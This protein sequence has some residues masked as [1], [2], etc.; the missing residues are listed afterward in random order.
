M[1]K[2]GRQFAVFDMDG[3]LINSEPIWRRVTRDTVVKQYGI[4]PGDEF[5]VINSGSTTLSLSYELKRLYPDA[6]VEPQELCNAIIEEMMPQICS[7]PLLP[8][9]AEIL[10]YFSHQSIS[11]AIASSSAMKL[12]E[13]VVRHHDFPIKAVASGYEV[14]SSK[15]H[16]AVF[17]L[18]AARLSARPVE[19]MAW[20][21]SVN[22]VIAA[23]S[24][25]MEVF[26]VPEESNLDMNMFS[27]AHHVH[28]TLQHSLGYLRSERG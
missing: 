5:I 4:D 19:C 12:I 17:E 20:E 21:D 11:I 8:G 23:Y 2:P 10:D 26:A 27:I 14:E 13:K 28:E 9:A 24:A 18:A 16:P 22:G 1:K 15:P 6:G 25:G 3:T 7:A